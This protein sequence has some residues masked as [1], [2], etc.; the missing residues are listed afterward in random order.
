[1]AVDRLRVLILSGDVL[2]RAGLA[3]RLSD[4]RELEVE[5]PSGADGARVPPDVAAW[6]VGVSRRVLAPSLP[7]VPTLALISD[8]EQAAAALAAGARGAV[9]RDAPPERL[10]EALRATAQGLVVLD[11]ALASAVLR[12][13][14]PLDEAQLPEPLTAREREVLGLLAEGLGNRAI[15]ARLG[16]S[17]HTAK[18][19]VNAILGKLGAESRTEAVV[20]ASRLGLVTL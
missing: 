12:P 11:E 8:L 18:F 14:A 7:D 5:V 10:V 15:A 19:H 1:V 6:D 17:E 2:A 20:V 3:A 13:F 16:V 9:F 4:E